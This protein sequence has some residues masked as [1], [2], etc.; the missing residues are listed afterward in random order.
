MTHRDTQYEAEKMLMISKQ[1]HYFICRIDD[2]LYV[3]SDG[4]SKEMLSKAWPQ[5][6]NHQ[7]NDA[8]ANEQ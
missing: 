1:M 4:G 5:S 6:S 7:H 3:K 2:S 8:P